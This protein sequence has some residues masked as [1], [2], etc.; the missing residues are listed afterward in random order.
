MKFFL[1]SFHGKQIT[2]DDYLP[3]YICNLC[4]RRLR[5]SYDFKVQCEMTDQTLREMLAYAPLVSKN[6]KESSPAENDPEDSW[7]PIYKTNLK[8][9]PANEYIFSSFA[10]FEEAITNEKI[11][12]EEHLED[13]ESQE[14]EEA[15][16]SEAFSSA[17]VEKLEEFLNEEADCDIVKNIE[18]VSNEKSIP[19]ANVFQEK[20]NEESLPVSENSLN[21]IEQINDAIATNTQQMSNTQ[22]QEN[23]TP[24][25]IFQFVINKSGEIEEGSFPLEVTAVNPNDTQV[26]LTLENVS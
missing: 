23:D 13:E 3:K 18:E 19:L 20:E 16:N 17:D 1:F 5:L 11:E 4:A 22:N 2:A 26:V 9:E 10:S 12:T 25:E 15:A 8:I 14:I 6:L 7:K 24:Q 21:F